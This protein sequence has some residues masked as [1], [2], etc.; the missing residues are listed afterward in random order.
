MRNRCGKRLGSVCRVDFGISSP[1][2]FSP[3][4]RRPSTRSPTRYEKGIAAHQG[5]IEYMSICAPIQRF[6]NAHV[7]K[8]QFGILKVRSRQTQHNNC[9]CQAKS[10]PSWGC[11]KS[12]GVPPMSALGIAADAAV[13]TSSS[14][15]M[16]TPEKKIH[17]ITRTLNW[18]QIHRAWHTGCTNNLAFLQA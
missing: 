11:F 4:H 10:K 12:V 3:T 15:P 16:G 9:K 7:I 18:L 5:R 14:K 6:R 1:S 2:P 17:R 8:L 13:L